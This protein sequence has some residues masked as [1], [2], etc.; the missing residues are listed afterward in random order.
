MSFETSLVASGMPA[1]RVWPSR[2]LAGL[3]VWPGI[4]YPDLTGWDL[5]TRRC[6]KA[7]IVTPFMCGKSATNHYYITFVK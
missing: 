5:P 1:C 6:M 3:S 4:S 2:R 7:G